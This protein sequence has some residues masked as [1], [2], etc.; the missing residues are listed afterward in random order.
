MDWRGWDSLPTAFIVA[1][2]HFGHAASQLIDGCYGMLKR[3]ASL[4]MNRC[5]EAADTTARVMRIQLL[6][7]PCLNG[8]DVKTGHRSR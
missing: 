6:D 8:N 2:T 7:L 3:M 5:I 4:P 1:E